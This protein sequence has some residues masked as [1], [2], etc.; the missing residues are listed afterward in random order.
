MALLLNHLAHPCFD[1]AATHRLYAKVLGLRLASVVDCGDELR[2]A[3]SLG[4]DRLLVFATAAGKA[5]LA[6]DTWETLHVGLFAASV[7]ERLDYRRQLEAAGVP[8]HIEDPGPEE[9]IYFRDPNGLVVEIEAAYLTPPQADAEAVL[10]AW[11][12][13]RD[14]GS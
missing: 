7:E 2:W 3:Y 5:P 10:S 11:S 6:D 8:L 4:G 1:V 13:R 9:R 12:R 14:G